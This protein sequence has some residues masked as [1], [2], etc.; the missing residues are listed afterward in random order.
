MLVLAAA[1]LMG[2]ALVGVGIVTLLVA[3]G[4]ALERLRGDPPP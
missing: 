4:L 2:N 3:I 1:G